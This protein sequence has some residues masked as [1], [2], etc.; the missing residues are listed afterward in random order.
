MVFLFNL[1]ALVSCGGFVL[2]VYCHVLGLQH[3]EPPW[4][5]SSFFLHIGIFVVWIPLVLFAERTKPQGTRNNLNH[6][7]ALLPTWLRF[8]VNGIF[9]Y[10]LVNFGYFMMQT[11]SYGKGETPF[12]LELR[13]FSGHW[14]MFYSMATAGFVALAR[15]YRKKLEEVS[16]R[17]N[18][19]E[20]K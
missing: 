1:L 7:M 2:S 3:L 15:L 11:H 20:P 12:Y 18:S 8:G 17:I 14:M 10:A 16:P 13:G 4:G 5:K 9:I 6:L 19:L